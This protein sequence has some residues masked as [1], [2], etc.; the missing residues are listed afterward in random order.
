[1]KAHS[2]KLSFQVTVTEI[3]LRTQSDIFL[4]GY[5]RHPE[6][7]V[8][9]TEFSL[10][11][12]S[13]IVPF[14]LLRCFAIGLMRR[15]TQLQSRS[16][17]LLGD[18]ILGRCEKL[19]L[20]DAQLQVENFRASPPRPASFSYIT[21]VRGLRYRG[22]ITPSDL[23]LSIG[24]RPELEFDP[25]RVS[26]C[27]PF[28]TAELIVITPPVTTG[29]NFVGRFS[30]PPITLQFQ[31]RFLIIKEI[32]PDPYTLTWCLYDIDSLGYHAP[33]ATIDGSGHASYAPTN[34]GHSVKLAVLE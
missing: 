17:S 1:M 30:G 5:E 33:V 24:Y 2:F 34:S 16:Q 4:Y 22:A 9:S 21:H 18:S 19:N 31:A 7:L 28:S 20:L 29:E 26:A 10:K 3:L 32:M 8:P 27:M 15:P 25:E 13:T 12:N 23:S 14:S 11:L 6:W